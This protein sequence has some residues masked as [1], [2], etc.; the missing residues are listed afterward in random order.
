MGSLPAQGANDRVHV[1][2]CAVGEG[3]ARLP[4]RLRSERA[5][6]QLALRAAD[7]HQG[8]IGVH[9]SSPLERTQF[10]QQVG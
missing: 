10:G 5:R 1:G 7:F 6:D 8:E 2:L 3:L 9:V 4:A